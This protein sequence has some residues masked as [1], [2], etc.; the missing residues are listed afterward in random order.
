MSYSKEISEMVFSFSRCHMFEECKYEWYLNYLLK[1]EN[2]KRIYESEQNFYGAYGNFCHELLQKILNKEIT[3]EEAVEIYQN[4]FDNE[5]QCFDV[6]DSIRDK[7]F[8]LGLDYFGTLDFEWLDDY[9]ILGIEELC[10]FK[11]G[12]YNFIGYIDLLIR[13][14]ATGKIIV[15][16]HKSSEYP[17]GKRG[18]VLKK[19]EEKYESYKKQLYVYSKPVFE[20]YGVYPSEIWWNYFKDQKWLKLPFIKEEYDASLK[21]AEDVIGEMKKE[22]DFIPKLDFFYCQNLCNFRNS[23]DYKIM[24]E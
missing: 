1:D 9:E 2:G 17:L 16:D 5:I 12:E 23:C 18:K 13:E 24:G 11:V 14:K 8:Y 10:K 7:Y 15:V 4:D 21:W 20:K 22:E 3:I 6:S 19:N